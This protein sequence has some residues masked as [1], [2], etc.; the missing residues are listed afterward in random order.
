MHQCR[1]PALC[2][3]AIATVFFVC[4]SLVHARPIPGTLR[5][6]TYTVEP[7]DSLW[8][9]A[10]RFDCRVSDLRVLNDCKSDLI[11]PGQVLFVPRLTYTVAQGDCLSTIAH[12]YGTNVRDLKAAN[13]L[14]SDLIRAGQVLLLPSYIK[15]RISRV[16]EDGL[17]IRSI[18]EE[19]LDLLVRLVHA[20]AAGESYIGKV[21][22]AASV[23]NRVDSPDYPNTITDVI[24]QVVGDSGYQYT[25]VANGRINQPGDAEAAMAVE[26]ALAGWDPTGGA[27][28]FYNPRFTNDTWVRSRKVVAVIDNHVFFI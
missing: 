13:G 16:S 11:R 12:K 26:A 17:L 14:E 25:P 6:V 21:A 5:A 2:L 9:I 15:P 23:L 27:T 20:E 10:R 1:Y 3:L 8:A 28:G 22:V 18:S 7:G 4:A 19:E 24:Y